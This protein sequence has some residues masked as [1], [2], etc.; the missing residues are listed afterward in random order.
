MTGEMESRNKAPR[1]RTKCNSCKGCRHKKTCTNPLGS[2]SLLPVGAP[3][4]AQDVVMPLASGTVGGVVECSGNTSKLPF[5]SADLALKDCGH[6]IASVL[7]DQWDEAL[8]APFEVAG[9]TSRRSGRYA[10]LCCSSCQVQ[11]SPNEHWQRHTPALCRGAQKLRQDNP[12]VQ[13]DYSRECPSVFGLKN[14][15][16][17]QTQAD[18]RSRAL[19]IENLPPPPVRDTSS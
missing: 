8:L 19:P 16:K 14:E 10:G 9:S 13:W 5:V 1:P 15:L 18:W 4:A 17:K 3:D 11:G 6:R 7:Q 12:D 2:K